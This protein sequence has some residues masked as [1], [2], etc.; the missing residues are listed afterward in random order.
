L[1]RCAKQDPNFSQV[2]M[3]YPQ[4]YSILSILT[5]CCFADSYQSCYE[6]F[7]IGLQSRAL[8]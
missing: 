1:H 3:L 7:I 5:W 4:T 8:N 6:K 2:A